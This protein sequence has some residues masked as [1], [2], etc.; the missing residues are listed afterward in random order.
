MSPKILK[1]SLSVS[2]FFKQ[3]IDFMQ[4]SKFDILEKNIKSTVTKAFD[5]STASD[6]LKHRNSDFLRFFIFYEKKESKIMNFVQ[7]AP[8]F[9]QPN[10]CLC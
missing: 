1:K 8:R 5:K 9:R 4:K 10:L 3:L 6:G 2:H 7:K